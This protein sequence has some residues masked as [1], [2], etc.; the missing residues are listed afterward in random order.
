MTNAARGSR[1]SAEEADNILRAAP[2]MT[3][4]D[5]MRRWGHTDNRQIR[6]LV[7]GRHPSGIHLPAIRFSNKVL[8]FRPIDVARVEEDLWEGG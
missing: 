3:E 8:R 5:L 6:K 4:A 2:L 1:Y 7:S